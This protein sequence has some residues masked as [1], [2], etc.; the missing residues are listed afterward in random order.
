MYERFFGLADAPFRLTPDPRY[1][2]LSPK[3]AEALAHLKLGL[4]ESSGFVCIT[5]DVGTGK[6]TLLRA[7]LAGLG[8][9]TATAYIFNPPLSALE[10]LKTINGELGLFA[11]TRSRKKL[12]DALNVHLLAQRE[13]GRRS[14]VIIDEAQALSI[15]VLEQL[16]LLSNL[17]TTTEKL[18]RIVLAGQPQLRALLLHPELVQLNQRIT[19]RWHMGPLSRRETVAYVLHRLRIAAGGDPPPRIFTRP[20]LRLVHRISRGV[21]RVVNMVAHRSMVAAFAAERRVVNAACVRQA[22]REIGALPLAA[23]A[24]ASRRTAWAAAAVGACLGV[25]ALGVVALA[26]RPE[27]RLGGASE[28]PAPSA[29]ATPAEETPAPA[30]AEVTPPPPA[31][32]P[33]PPEAAPAAPVPAADPAPPVTPADEVERRLASL[34]ARTSE[35]AAVGAILAAWHVRPLADDEAADLAQV[36]ARRGLEDLR[37]VGNGNMLR[38]LDL[39][40]ILE[41]HIPGAD[42]PRA[43]ALTGMSDG[44]SVL[45]IDGSPTPVDAAFLDRHWFGAAHV[46]WR[47]FEALGRTFGRGWHGAPVARLQ[48]LLRRAGAYEGKETGQLDAATEAAVRAF[49]RARFLAVDGRVGRLTRIVLYAAAGGYPRPALGASS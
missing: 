21:P 26:W 27:L 6:T 28:S 4:R 46:L 22:Y 23:A 33:A 48:A 37:L 15:D 12:V 9:E 14:I 3:H 24:P 20:A 29:V 5:G 43:V 13:A 44:R 16:R 31:A 47:D 41:L 42:Q 10:L 2:F 25:V 1:L 11:K 45:V 38:L 7:F 18:L 49:Q 40:A 32:E 34:D 36:A 17:E 30:V 35:R 19:L 8:P 39:P